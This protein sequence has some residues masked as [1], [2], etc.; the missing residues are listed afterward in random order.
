MAET[1]HI[2]AAPSF[3][4][5]GEHR[6][7]L[8]GVTFT[9]TSATES[10]YWFTRNRGHFDQAFGKIMELSLAKAI[11]TSLF[12]GNEVQFPGSY[13]ESHFERGF[14]FEW[15][16]IYFVLPVPYSQECTP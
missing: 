6:G 11:V 1:F 8:K 13:S 10:R 7:K 16:P 9:A 5:E 12:R 4:T 15:S 3:F 2:S 14:M